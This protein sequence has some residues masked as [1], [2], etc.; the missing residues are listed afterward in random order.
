MAARA[1][2]DHNPNPSLKD[3]H[4][5]LSGNFC[6]CGTYAGM[7]QAVL[8]AAAADAGDDDKKDEKKKGSG[9]PPKEPKGVA[10]G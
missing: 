10:H 6:R 7:R 3:V 4:H 1:L 9:E 5:G 2:L 8:A